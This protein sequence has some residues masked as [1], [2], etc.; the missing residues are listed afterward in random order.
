M[1]LGQNGGE[2]WNTSLILTISKQNQ[3]LGNGM[4][5]WNKKWKVKLIAA[6]MITCND[7]DDV[8]WPRQYYMVTGFM[9]CVTRFTG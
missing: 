8:E 9:T 3:C 1:M 7:A 4:L 6:F 5:H 2:L